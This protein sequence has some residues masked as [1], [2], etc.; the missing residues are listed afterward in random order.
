MC[1]KAVAN[2][3]LP[4]HVKTRNSDRN[5][6]RFRN[7]RRCPAP[8]ARVVSR[9]FNFRAV[10]HRRL[11]SNARGLRAR[12][13]RQRRCRGDTVIACASSGSSSHWPRAVASWFMT[14]AATS[15]TPESALS[16]QTGSP[17]RRASGRRTRTSAPATRRRPYRPTSAVSLD[18]PR[19]TPSDAWSRGGTRAADVSAAQS[20][21]AMRSAD[22]LLRRSQRS[23]QL[24][25]AAHCR[26]QRGQLCIVAEHRDAATPHENDDAAG[27]LQHIAVTRPL[28]ISQRKCVP[29]RAERG[30]ELPPDVACSMCAGTHGR[31]DR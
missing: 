17:P 15:S 29:A 12:C 19:S 9:L 30:L 3:L 25:I 4:A 14:R 18:G 20:F 27:E 8:P 1:V 24:E 26:E 22:G 7:E 13:S 28:Q 23:N 31:R 21:D 11:G 2:V 6:D 10:Y 16:I 5:D